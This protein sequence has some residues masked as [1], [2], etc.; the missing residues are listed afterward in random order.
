MSDLTHA[1]CLKA[2]CHTLRLVPTSLR[3][4]QKSSSPPPWWAF[5]AA[6]GQTPFG[7]LPTLCFSRGSPFWL[8]RCLGTT[9]VQICRKSRMVGKPRLTQSSSERPRSPTSVIRGTT[10]SGA[11]PSLASG[12]SA[13]AVTSLSARKVRLSCH[14]P[15]WPSLAPS[16]TFGLAQFLWV[17]VLG[18]NRS[19]IHRTKTGGSSHTL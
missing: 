8:Q 12:T 10:L 1:T 9:R 6:Q 15:P 7:L 3:A 16:H 5:I 18:S 13:G 11:T 14:S 2:T 4:S 19:L 17:L